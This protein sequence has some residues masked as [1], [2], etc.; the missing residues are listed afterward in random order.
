MGFVKR[1]TAT[2]CDCFLWICLTCRPTLSGFGISSVN[3]MFFNH[4]GENK[5]QLLIRT[6]QTQLRFSLCKRGVE[7]SK[8]VLKINI[9]HLIEWS[10][11][12]L[13]SLGIAV[14]FLIIDS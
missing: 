6:P 7:N 14:R 13:F 12:Y 1:D 10:D 3:G 4:V 11:I 2:Q 9:Y 8:R 5:N